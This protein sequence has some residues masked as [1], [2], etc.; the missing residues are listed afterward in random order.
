MSQIQKKYKNFTLLCN[1][2]ECDL[3]L[4]IIIN[5]NY[6]IDKAN[7]HEI[8]I[9]KTKHLDKIKKSSPKGRINPFELLE[10][11]KIKSTVE[12]QRDGIKANSAS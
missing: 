8:E 3:E 10:L 2:I 12:N 7:T 11:N 9:I 1:R 6:C 5:E 4:P